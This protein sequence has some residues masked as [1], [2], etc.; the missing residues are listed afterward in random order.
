VGLKQRE[1][2]LG[3]VHD[4][5]STKSREIAANN[6]RLRLGI[7]GTNS[8][9]TM[10]RFA[11][12]WFLPVADGRLRQSTA[13]DYRWR[14][15]KYIAGRIEAR[16][17]LWEYRTVDVQNLLNGIAYDHPKLAKASLQRI[18]ALL[19][20]IFR[21]AVT[22]GFREGNPVRD[23][24]L[25]GRS[26]TTSDKAGNG[27]NRTPGVYDLATVRLVLKQP[28]PPEVKAATAIAALAGL[29]LAE[30]RGLR[31]EDIGDDAITIS[32]TIWSTYTNAPKSKAS[33]ASVPVIPELAKHLAAY[34]RYWDKQPVAYTRAT[35]DSEP[36]PD[37][38]LFGPKLYGELRYHLSR[39]FK[40]AGG[41]YRGT[42]AFRRGLASELFER[43]AEDLDVSHVL[44]HSKV[45]VTRDSYIKKFDSRVLD[46]MNSLAERPKSKG[47]VR[48]KAKS[49]T[50]RKQ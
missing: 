20:G 24:L 30:L 23:V 9:V 21:H 26:Q 7:V 35:E 28:M 38:S 42:H 8:N 6:V 18:K 5:P 34:K 1:I 22:A 45:I 48:D 10:E 40:R 44:R 33:A 14:F 3:S 19:S 17:P 11:T 29:R 43:G 12:N 13:K 50:P 16:M 41:E 31:W 2:T 49:Q 4:L 27:S 47:Q 36:V 39:A 37:T 32:R 15:G 46:A 25:P